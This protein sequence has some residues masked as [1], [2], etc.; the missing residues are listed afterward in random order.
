ME[1]AW[2]SDVFLKTDF[3]QFVKKIWADYLIERIFEKR[4]NKSQIYY[5]ELKCVTSF[6]LSIT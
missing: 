2:I 5:M 6:H 1:S 4:E 3:C